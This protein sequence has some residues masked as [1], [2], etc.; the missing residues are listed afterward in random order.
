MMTSLGHQMS[1][2]EISDMIREADSDDKGAIDFPE[3]LAFLV[4]KMS[5]QDPEEF[6]AEMF[7]L[8]DKDKNGYVSFGDLKQQ[9]ALAGENLTEQ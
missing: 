8:Y 3:F 5:E 6:Y 2:Q 7:N 1:K 9:M 4:R